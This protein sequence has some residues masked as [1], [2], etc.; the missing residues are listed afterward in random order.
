MP[1]VQTI[2][3]MNKAEATQALKDLGEVVH[4]SWTSVEIKS[5]LV[6]LKKREDLTHNKQL[7]GLHG[8]KKDELVELA[9]KELGMTQVRAEKETVIT[10]RERIRARRK[11]LEVQE[12]PLAVMPVGAGKLGKED[13]IKLR[14]ERGVYV[15]GATKPQM[16]CKLKDQVDE[17]TI[18]S[19][20]TQET[21]ST[22]SEA[23]T[24]QMEVDGEWSLAEADKTRAKRK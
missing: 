10:L 1:I 15:D 11:M 19:T 3:A 13:L 7:R 22:R 16:M 23:S 5:K 21:A 24:G 18:L 4:P 8:M 9:L 6:E 12:D 2:S 17:R 20:T 14:K